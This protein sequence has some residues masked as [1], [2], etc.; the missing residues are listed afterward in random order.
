[1]IRRTTWIALGLFLVLLV[2]ALYLQRNP[3]STEVEATP[4]IALR[5][6]EGV[7]PEDLVAVTIARD[8]DT[9]VT[10]SRASGGAWRLAGVSAEETAQTRVETALAQLVP[11]PVLSTIDADVDPVTVGLAP[12]EVVITF[13][14]GAGERFSLEVGDQTPTGG[15]YYVRLEGDPPHVVGAPAVEN[16]IGFVDD[17]PLVPT[18]E[19]TP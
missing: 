13:E 14:T 7:L 5:L 9:P 3:P 16:A 19:P 15:G 10:L 4:T 11:L 12:P 1:M 6:M 2:V 17:P 8:G 18:P